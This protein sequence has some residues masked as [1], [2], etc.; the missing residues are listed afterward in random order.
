VSNNI[1]SDEDIFFH[2]LNY[3]IIFSWLTILVETTKK[4]KSGAELRRKKDLKKLFMAN[5]AAKYGID[6]ELMD[7]VCTS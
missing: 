3:F 2:V 7:N 4:C 5:Q 1:I 6:T